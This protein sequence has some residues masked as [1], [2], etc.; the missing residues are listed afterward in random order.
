LDPNTARDSDG[1]LSGA[2]PFRFI[3]EARADD[4]ARIQQ[5]QRMIDRILADRPIVRLGEGAR[6]LS[7]IAQNQTAT[8]LVTHV[9]YMSKTEVKQFSE[10]LKA[11]GTPEVTCLDQVFVQPRLNS[12]TTLLA[13]VGA[14][15]AMVNAEM[16]AIDKPDLTIGISAERS[17]TLTGDVLWALGGRRTETVNFRVKELSK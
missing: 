8:M 14:V 6:T 3:T 4:Q 17:P 7:I 15:A 1:D 5:L 11:P 16:F 12:F 2:A 9:C 10:A 13:P